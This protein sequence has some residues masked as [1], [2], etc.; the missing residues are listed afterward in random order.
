MEDLTWLLCGCFFHLQLLSEFLLDT[1]YCLRKKHFTS[2]SF[3]SLPLTSTRHIL[4]CLDTLEF[5]SLYFSVLE[6]ITETAP[7]SESS[8]SMS[9][10][11]VN[12]WQAS[13]IYFTFSFFLKIVYLMCVWVCIACVYAHMCGVCVVHM[14][15]VCIACVC[16]HVCGVCM[17]VLHMCVV[18]V[19]VWVCMWV[20]CAHTKWHVWRGE[21]TTSGVSSLDP[22]QAVS[23][24][25]LVMP[26]PPPNQVPLTW[27]RKGSGL[28]ASFCSIT[29]SCPGPL[30]EFLTGNTN[31]DQDRCFRPFS[32][33]FV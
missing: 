4:R 9:T 14:C 15:V 27:S 7:G 13:F 11:A 6:G 31:T 33:S 18:C 29:N 19:S 12:P 10:T 32:V 23:T 8:C 26:D 25:A 5:F 22:T 3:L 16:T 20:W 30:S 24:W 1:K 17:C 28:A 21:R 2:S